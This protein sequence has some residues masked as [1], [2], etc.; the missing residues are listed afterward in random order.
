MHCVVRVELDSSRVRFAYPATELLLLLLI[1]DSLAGRQ[2]HA[3]SLDY[4]SRDDAASHGSP[5]SRA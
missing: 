3:L 4:F 5:P 1:P 2:P